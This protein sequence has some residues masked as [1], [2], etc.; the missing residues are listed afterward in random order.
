[1]RTTQRAPRRSTG[2][3]FV[4][5]SG[6]NGLA[7]AVRL[8]QAGLDVTVLE[9]SDRIGGGLRT[10]ERTVPGLLHDDCAAFHPT[11][12]ASPFLQT[13]DLG[14]HGLTFLWPEVQ[15]GHPLDSGE[16]GLVVRSVAETA[17][18][19]GADGP[20]WSRIF[21]PL[22]R[23]YDRLT[24]DLFGPVLHVPH[25]PLALA[26]FGPAALLPATTVARVWSGE[27]AKALYGGVAAHLIAPLTTPLSASVG[28]MLGAAAHAYGWPVA[29]GGSAAIAT[30]L[31][32]EL[33]ALGGTVEPGV[34][35]T[36]V[37]Q[38]AAADVVLLDLAPDAVLRLVGDRMPARVRRAYG[39]YRFGPGAFKV[40]LAVEGGLPWRNPD[41]GRAGTVHLGG[42]LAEMVATEA[43]IARGRMPDRPFVL[44]GQQSV[45]DPSRSVGDLH[46][47]YAY[48]HV[49]AGYAGDATEA[50]IDQIERFAPGTRERIVGRFAR[51]PAALEADN[52]N[53]VGGDIATGANAGRQVVFRPRIG[54][55][56]YA[57]GVPGV[58]L[59][60]AASPPG[61]G[62]HGMAGFHAAEA[63]LADLPR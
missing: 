46:P 35:V 41:L 19:L 44:L 26:R 53:Y 7:G 22:A 63:A 36:D 11:G 49:P 37:R 29:Q 30:A 25:H 16:A 42:T 58:Y 56:P 17:T 14:R 50:V 18:T 5:G 34:R 4:V 9:A 6:P 20:A 60:S 39:R 31:V 15:Y 48:A 28:L 2:R 51:G 24:E 57:T 3:A 12:V 1:M 59:C 23:D 38:L 54:P 13:L 43:E 33:T 40:D 55:N 32:A 21:G 10:S 62:A 47:I 8:A 61:A 27:V 52:P 45:V